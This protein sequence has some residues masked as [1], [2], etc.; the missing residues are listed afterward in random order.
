MGCVALAAALA[1]CTITASPQPIENRKF[2]DAPFNVIRAV[3]GSG[4]STFAMG[5]NN[6][7]CALTL[8]GAIARRYE[9]WTT[10]QSNGVPSWNFTPVR[11]AKP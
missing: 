7:F 3:F 8:S 4:H 10:A 6:C 9:N 5:A 11:R 2:A 1:G